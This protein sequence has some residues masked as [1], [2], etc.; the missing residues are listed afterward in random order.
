MG[1]L[2]LSPDLS[3]CA[4]HAMVPLAGT[5]PVD[6]L[7]DTCGVWQPEKRRCGLSWEGL[8]RSFIAPLMQYAVE[9]LSQIAV[10]VSSS[11]SYIFI[12]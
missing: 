10:A 1:D 5:K 4:S 2:Q 7:H 8:F 6:L 11:E 3:S 12:N 9:E